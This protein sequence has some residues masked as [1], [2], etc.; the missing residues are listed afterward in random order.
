MLK[1]AEQI[2]GIRAASQVTKN[3]LDGLTDLI[4]IGTTT[5]QIDD[6]VSLQIKNAGGTAATLGYNGFPKSCCTSKNNVICHGIPDDI[7]LVDGDIINVDVTTI[8]NGYYGDACRMYYVGNVSADA[9]KLCE[10][11]V[12][13]KLEGGKSFEPEMKWTFKIDREAAY[14]GK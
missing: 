3:I 13:W 14:Q 6:W 7:P 11:A 2:A 4:Q 12:Y 1:N 10:V 9:Q 5:N 8:L